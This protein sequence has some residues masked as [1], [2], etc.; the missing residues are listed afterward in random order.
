M[1]KCDVG[2]FVEENLRVILLSLLLLCLLAQLP[3]IWYFKNT[4]ALVAVTPESRVGNQ[5]A[6]RGTRVGRSSKKSTPVPVI[7]G[8]SLS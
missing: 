5:N 4:K 3:A 2:G 6:S 1:N 8:E 7:Y